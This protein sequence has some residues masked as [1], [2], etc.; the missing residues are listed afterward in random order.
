MAKGDVYRLPDGGLAID[1]QSDVIY[2]FG[3][4]LV[5]PLVAPGAINRPLPRLMPLVTVSLYDGSSEQLVLATPLMA[6]VPVK[7]LGRP[8]AALDQE[9]WGISAAIDMLLTGC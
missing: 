7:P 5:I 4:R 2:G 1:V 3:T 9:H 6:A 8:V